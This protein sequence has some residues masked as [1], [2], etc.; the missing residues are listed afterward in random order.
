MSLH[1]NLL[2]R[3]RANTTPLSKKLR[4]VADYVLDNAHDVQF[5]TITELA[6]NSQTSE[7]TV[8]RLCRDMGYKGYSDF[9]MA[10][11][12]DLS[13]NPREK[14]VEME[15]DIC[16]VSAQRAVASLQDTAQIIDRKAL[17]RVCELVHKSSY[18]SCVGVGASSIVGRYLTFRLLRIGKKVNMYEDTHLAAMNAVR[19]TEGDL[20][21]A[22]SSSGSTKEVVHA[23]RQTHER[24]VPVVSITNI[25]HSALSSI[26]TESLIAARP[27]GPL[28]GGAF[29]SKVGALL[30]VDVLVN[31]LL[32]QYPEYKESV[33]E[34]AEVVMP[35]ML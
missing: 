32:E 3:L 12:V 30:L 5:Q 9:R 8:V 6:R 1:N 34:T 24:N 17:E 23:V 15:G 2:V 7:A 31:T 18:I 26:S 28:T 29:A 19:S 13:Q 20:W 14:Q 33:V 11:A 21:F 10:L 22:V 27:E 16:H 25:T 35:L 4:L